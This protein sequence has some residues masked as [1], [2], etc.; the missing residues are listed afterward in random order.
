MSFAPVGSDTGGR[1][2]VTGF[3]RGASPGECEMK[4]I[5]SGLVVA[6]ALFA[7]ADVPAQRRGRGGR[8]RPRQ[9]A[10]ARTAARVEPTR[11]LS[12][13]MIGNRVIARLAD[14]RAEFDYTLTGAQVIDGRLQFLGS[15]GEPG[16]GG[17]AVETASATLVGTL[18]R[19]REPWAWASEPRRPKP[20]AGQ[21][22][23]QPQGRE[24]RNP[25]TAGQIGPLS[26]ATQSTARTTQTP[27]APE[28]KKPAEGQVTE[29]TQS[30]YT[31]IDVGSG[32]DVL[33]MKMQLPPRL[34]ARARAAEHVQIGVVLVPLDNKRG[35]EINRH[36]C[37][38]VRALSAG[39]GVEEQL[40]QLNRL[41]SGGQ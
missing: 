22:G 31:A 14:D 20:A 28:A 16:R 12:G 4:K 6:V 7:A 35:E 36:V 2:A 41:L 32:C 23:A 18:G 17:V 24:A 5:C 38:V 30:L 11:T 9:S 10:V 1:A 40:T 26:Q 21:Q 29:Q 8:A 25:E 33:Y 27:T 19:S 39:Q 15:V 3:S 37:R 13:R 34:A